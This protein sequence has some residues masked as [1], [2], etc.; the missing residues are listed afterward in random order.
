MAT[1]MK[2]RPEI[3][4]ENSKYLAEMV[5]S[6]SHLTD[7]EL[8]ALTH[9]RSGLHTVCKFLPTPADVHAFLRDREE[10]LKAV[11][12]APTTYKR[13]NVDDPDAPWNRETDA[14]RKRRVVRETLGYDPDARGH[15]G[16]RS[17]TAAS[18]EDVANLRLKTPAA[19]PSPQLIAK[20]EAE[21][22]PFVP[23]PQDQA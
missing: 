21:G 2:G 6:L 16:K 4:T 9:P 11:M 19:P 13:L 3:Q 5:E 15:H 8:A 18:A 20:L 17:L 1:L 22:Y 23:K 14:E 10:R 12:P 7:S